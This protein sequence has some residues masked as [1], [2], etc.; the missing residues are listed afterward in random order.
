MRL[1]HLVVLF[2][3]FLAE[4][5]QLSA[6]ARLFDQSITSEAPFC[7]PTNTISKLADSFKNDTSGAVAWHRL[8]G[9]ID[10]AAAR[11]SD[12][13]GSW[14]CLAAIRTAENYLQ[15]LHDQNIYRLDL[16]RRAIANHHLLPT[17]RDLT[18]LS[19]PWLDDG[20]ERISG[21]VFV[22]LWQAHCLE[23]MLSMDVVKAAIR[24]AQHACDHVGALLPTV[25]DIL[26]GLFAGTAIE[27]DKKLIYSNTTMAVD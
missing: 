16:V 18:S 7:L 11:V 9:E 2:G 12:T 15:Q 14:Q 21:G 27:C 25:N 5:S 23:P 26:K 10:A 3:S 8:L 4:V 13:R 24:D 1:T 17:P 19:V 20:C 6:S 22:L